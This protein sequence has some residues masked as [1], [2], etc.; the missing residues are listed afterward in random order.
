V[1]NYLPHSDSTNLDCC[2]SEYLPL[3]KVLVQFT[4]SSS[5]LITQIHSTSVFC[6]FR[7][8]TLEISDSDPDLCGQPT[9]EK[10]SNTLPPV[11]ATQIPDEYLRQTEQT[12]VPSHFITTHPTS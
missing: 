10:N 4:C 7:F 6:F 1:N 9:E 8:Q 12:K 5:P 11:S 2:F 3:P